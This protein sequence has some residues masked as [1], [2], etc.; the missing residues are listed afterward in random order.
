MV[1]FMC[2][3]CVLPLASRGRSSV[4]TGTLESNVEQ[5]GVG[6]SPHMTSELTVYPSDK[7]PLICYTLRFNNPGVCSRDG[8][9]LRMKIRK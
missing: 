1:V 5:Q 3:D 4:S 6:K 2:R 8:S 9:W 7:K